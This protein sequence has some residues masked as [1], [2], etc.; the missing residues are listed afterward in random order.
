M[1]VVKAQRLC[2]DAHQSLMFYF[3][4][5]EYETPAIGNETTS[6]RALEL[7][8]LQYTKS[9]SSAKVVFFFRLV[10]SLRFPP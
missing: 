9:K 1:I 2:G 8:T 5:R 4:S 7:D 10:T 6:T 3:L